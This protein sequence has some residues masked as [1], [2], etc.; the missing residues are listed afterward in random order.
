MKNKSIGYSKAIIALARKIATIIWHLITNE[1]MY[2]DETGYKKKLD[3]KRRKFR[4]EKLLR[5]R[6]SQLM[7]E[8]KIMSEIYVIARNNER[9]YLRKISSYTFMLNKENLSK[10]QNERFLIFKN[11]NLKTVRVYNI[12]LSLQ[13][14]WD[15][16]NHKEATLYLQKWNFW[17][18]HNRL[19]PITEAA[20]TIKKHWNGILN[21]FRFQDN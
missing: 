17:A 3:I 6:Y 1:E 4:R 7:N 10:K 13:E 15:L 18:T 11:Q 16:H 21:Y 8:S 19:T 2:E 5:P 20:N 14:Y 9:E 12:K